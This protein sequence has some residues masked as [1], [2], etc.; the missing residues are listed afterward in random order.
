M[1]REEIIQHI[2]KASGE[3]T[4]ASTMGKEGRELFETC[5]ANN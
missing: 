3:D 4:I 5:V 2:V 1:V